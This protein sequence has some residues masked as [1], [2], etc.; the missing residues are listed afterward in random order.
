MKLLERRRALIS[1]RKSL[2]PKEYQ[3]VE[4]IEST[5]T[6]YINTGVNATLE[7]ME[8]FIKFKNSIIDNTFKNLFGIATPIGRYGCLFFYNGKIYAAN[9]YNNTNNIGAIIYEKNKIS[10]CILSLNDGIGTLNVDG[11][12]VTASYVTTNLGLPYQIFNTQQSVTTNMCKVKLY[13]CIISKNN[14]IV[15]DFIPCYR[16]SDNV[17]GLYDIVNDTFYTNIGTGEFLKGGDV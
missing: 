6:Q 17:V 3:Q 5:G 12:S 10:E 11:A 14:V 15:R 2:L 1:A 4:Y 13:R 7:D 9:N 16:K 8:I